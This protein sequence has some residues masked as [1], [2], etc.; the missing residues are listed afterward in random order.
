[1]LKTLGAAA[2]PAKLEGSADSKRDAAPPARNR[3]NCQ[4]DHGATKQAPRRGPTVPAP[5]MSR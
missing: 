4:L 5:Q 2:D 1:M 3:G